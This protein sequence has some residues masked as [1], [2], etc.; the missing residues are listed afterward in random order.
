[1]WSCVQGVI[2]SL[3]LTQ[4]WAYKYDA[5]SHAGI[6]IHADKAQVNLNLW[7]S[8]DGG[9]DIDGDGMTVW[10]REPPDGWSFTDWNGPDT[11]HQQAMREFVQ[12]SPNISV[13]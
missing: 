7:L 2:G 6:D 13:P 1:M 11:E 5:Q 4:V 8:P 10:T 9:D 3:P 12:G